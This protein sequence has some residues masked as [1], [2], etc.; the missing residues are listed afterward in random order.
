MIEDIRFDE[1]SIDRALKKEHLPPR[2][3]HLND[4]RIGFLVQLSPAS[5]I[6]IVEP[7]ELLSFFFILGV[8]GGLIVIEPV[9][10]LADL[11]VGS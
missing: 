8:V 1:V 7:V 2:G 3:I 11:Y 10:A 4:V 5:D 6:G 9:V